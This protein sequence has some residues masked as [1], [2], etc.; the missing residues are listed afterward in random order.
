MLIIEIYAVSITISG[1]KATFILDSELAFFKSA[2]KCFNF[3]YK[4]NIY[5]HKNLS[6]AQDQPKAGLP[7]P[8][9]LGDSFLNGT[10]H[11]AAYS[12]LRLDFVPASCDRTSPGNLHID[13]DNKSVRTSLTNAVTANFLHLIFPAAHRSS[14][15]FSYFLPIIITLQAT[16]SLPSTNRNTESVEFQGKFDPSRDDLDC[17]AI[18]DPSNQT[19]RLEVI[20]GGQA[21]LRHMPGSKRDKD[22]GNK[23]GDTSKK[24]SVGGVKSPEKEKNIAKGNASVPLPPPP[25]AP[26]TKKAAPAALLNVSQEEIADDFFHGGLD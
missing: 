22:V 9:L 13:T 21:T 23:L 17:V 19:F 5:I 4:F 10:L 6:M 24:N 1:F 14:S 7:Y 11:S 15:D 12:T 3:N 16:L 26:K 8:I 25:A 18:F 2:I 20:N